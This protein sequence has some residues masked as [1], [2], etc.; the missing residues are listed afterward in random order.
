MKV[1]LDEVLEI[2]DRA[3][4]RYDGRGVDAAMIGSAFGQMASGGAVEALRQTRDE[5]EL[6]RRPEEPR[7]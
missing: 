1:E 4:R 3:I 5:L 7:T 6:L 2:V